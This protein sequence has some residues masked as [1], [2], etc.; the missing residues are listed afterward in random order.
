[1]IENNYGCKRAKLVCPRAQNPMWISRCLPS[2]PSPISPSLSSFFPY[3][4]TNAQIHNR[5]AVLT[6][7][8]THRRKTSSSLPNLPPP[9]N[10]NPNN[11]LLLP[12]PNAALSNLAFDVWKS[13]SAA[14]TLKSPAL[15]SW[16]PR[17]LPPFAFPRPPAPPA[18]FVT[19][20]SPSARST[21]C[22]EAAAE[23][24]L[25]PLAAAAAAAAA[26]PRGWG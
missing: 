6:Q 24:R 12:P 22:S 15:I 23:L 20:R 14:G 21:L 16:C 9:S 13:K 25:P 2:D 8:P 17:L 26:E 3:H 5:L 18:P 7:R 11:A 4:N 19:L 10:N 1:M